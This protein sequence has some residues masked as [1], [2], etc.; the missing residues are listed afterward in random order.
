MAHS[1]RH[2]PVPPTALATCPAA[3]AA[4]TSA[5]AVVSG[6]DPHPVEAAEPIAMV[7]VLDRHRVV[8]VLPQRGPRPGHGRPQR[9]RERALT[10]PDQLD[11]PPLGH[12]LARMRRQAAQQPDTQSE[13]VLAPGAH[14][15]LRR[16]Q[17]PDTHQS[18]HCGS[19]STTRL[20]VSEGCPAKPEKRRLRT[21][22]ATTCR[23]GAWKPDIAAAAS[24]E[25][26]KEVVYLYARW[27]SP[28][29]PTTRTLPQ[30]VRIL[31]QGRS[32]QSGRRS[33]RWSRH[34]SWW[35]LWDSNPQPT[36]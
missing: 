29:A 3:T 6:V 13:R 1:T 19:A 32:H 34:C 33:K 15:D 20:H 14:A 36:D 26:R 25:A 31:A 8:A 35:D 12:Q 10:A 22:A 23:T 17:N 7:K 27:S 18:S 5:A 4:A 9:R 21:S 24:T 2:F 30:R 16:T 11:Q 28:N